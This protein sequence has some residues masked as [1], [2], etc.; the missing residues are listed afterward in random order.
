MGKGNYKERR[1]KNCKEKKK[2]KYSGRKRE[3]L[4][5]KKREKH[6][7]K[8]KELKEKENFKDLKGREKRKKKGI[9]NFKDWKGKEYKEKKNVI[10][11]SKERK[12]GMCKERKKGNG[13]DYELSVPRREKKIRIVQTTEN[14]QKIKDIIMITEVIVKQSITT[15]PKVDTIINLQSLLILSLPNKR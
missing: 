9:K 2:E 1:K 3:K 14:Y 7:E 4:S 5:V 11:R 15:K 6:K 12:N 8:K 13:R 10:E